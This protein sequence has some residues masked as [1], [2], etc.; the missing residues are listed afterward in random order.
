MFFINLFIKNNRDDKLNDDTLAELLAHLRR[1]AIGFYKEEQTFMKLVEKSIYH[2]YNK[3]E[4][5]FK[6]DNKLVQKVEKIKTKAN[7]TEWIKNKEC[8]DPNNK[9]GINNILFYSFMLYNNNNTEDSTFDDNNNN[10]NKIIIQRLKNISK[11]WLNPVGKYIKDEV[12]NCNIIIDDIFNKKDYL[13]GFTLY[14]KES[15]KNLENSGIDYV[16]FF[17]KFQKIAQIIKPK[18]TAEVKKK[19]NSSITEYKNKYSSQNNG[20]TQTIAD[21]EALIKA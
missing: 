9:T 5:T 10:N 20:D 21:I 17:N 13:E 8:T 11:R 4:N 1:S 16:G 18:I 12:D 6:N 2:N 3:D 15:M 14:T 7:I 19:Y